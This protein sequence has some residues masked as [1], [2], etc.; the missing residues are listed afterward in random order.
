MKSPNRLPVGTNP[1]GKPIG[2]NGATR[3]I[4]EKIDK[5]IEVEFKPNE[6]KKLRRKYGNKI[7]IK[8]IKKYTW[9]LPEIKI[10]VTQF[11]VQRA[12]LGKM[13]IA[14]AV[15]PELPQRG[16]FGNNLQSFIISLKN[17][18]AGSDEKIPKF[19][20]DLTQELFSQQAINNS[21]HRV[22]EY[23]ESD[24]KCLEKE[25][26]E[27]KIIGSDETGWRMN[28]E[29]WF[30]WL[31][32]TMNIVFITIQNSR[33]RAVLTKILGTTY[34]GTIIS[35]CFTAYQKIAKYYQKCW[36]HL[37]RKTHSLAMEFKDKDIVK[38]HKYLT[39]LF[40]EMNNFLKT[41]PNLIQREE[42]YIEF[43]KIIEDITNYNWKSKPAKDIVKNWLVKYK[44]HWLTAIK[45]SD[46][47]LT[48]NDTERHIRSSIPTRKLLGGHRTEDGAKYFAITE[49]LRK[50][51]KLR[52]L[53]PYHEM[54]KKF[55]EI[56]L[57]QAL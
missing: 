9:D 27:S 20:E 30:L 21:I 5:K 4:P 29:K 50:T 17:D 39:N 46:V 28:G 35:D 41:K 52:G 14:Q 25:L 8:T 19:I 57:N 15:H 42:K 16:I 32:C 49:S 10:F 24:Y 1:R 37:L 56:N 43:N 54:I 44:G 36:S 47:N 3:K 31:L 51:W 53:S 12:Y 26:R 34:D 23:L 45:I 22:G 18:F 33:S 55:E 38:L 11:N 48:N 7:T 6:I 40:N 2:S 13:M